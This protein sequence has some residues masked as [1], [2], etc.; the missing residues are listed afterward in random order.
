MRQGTALDRIIADFFRYDFVP[1]VLSRDPGTI[2]CWEKTSDDE[3]FK[4][5]RRL[6]REE[7]IL[8]GGSSGSA[9]AG[10]ISWLKSPIGW[11]DYGSVDGK[12]V[13]IILPDGSLPIL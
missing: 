3:S 9:L 1:E 6:I 2:D 7:G 10:A 4:W 13:V 12:N 11:Q 8:V 5:A